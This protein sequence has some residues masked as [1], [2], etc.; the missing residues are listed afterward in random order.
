[1]IPLVEALFW[2]TGAVVERY[3]VCYDQ[4]ELSVSIVV[5]PARAGIPDGWKST[6]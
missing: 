2:Q 6:G 4:G 5:Y 3:Q 1:M